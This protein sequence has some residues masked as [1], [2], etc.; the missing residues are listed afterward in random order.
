M[1]KACLS[2]KKDQ[3]R[4]EQ[5]T[6]LICQKIIKAGPLSFAAYMQ[7]VLYHPTLGYYS[8]LQQLGASGDF[9][10]APEISTLFGQCL[11]QQISSILEV[12]DEPNILE[13]GAG[14]GQLAIDILMALRDRD[15]CLN[16]YFI[17]EL[18]SSLKQIQQHNLKKYLPDFYDR[19]IWLDRLPTSF[20]GIMIAN[21]VLDAM[22]VHRFC[23]ENTGVFAYA[24][25][26]LKDQLT[27]ILI[28]ADRDL[29]HAMNNRK[30]N[31]LPPYSTEISLLIPAWIA[32][33]ANCLR[34]GMVFLI[35]Y[36]FPKSVYY[37]PERSMGT[38]M[39]HYQHRAHTDPYFLPGRQDIT[40]YVDF[41][42]VA[43][44][45]IMNGLELSGYTTQAHFLL[46]CGLM[47]LAQ[48]QQQTAET[49]WMT[50]QAI[51]R[52]ILPTEMGERFKVMALSKGLALPLMGF[53]SG[54]QRHFL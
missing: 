13:F 14:S 36:G 11:A 16:H 19:I 32:S 5:L 3:Q 26:A 4:T 43:E 6:K 22:P 25:D 48:S 31:C 15:S 51:K 33:L 18:S 53:T 9:V 42:T 54:D 8:Q 41:T 23:V 2:K 21:E 27:E 29:I 44:A 37:H 28:P 39:C 24:V 20:S 47:T 1:V 49:M 12:C 7:L 34:S 45:A 40:A 46:N 30:I 38:L 35:D 52:L 17:L 10:T 50:S